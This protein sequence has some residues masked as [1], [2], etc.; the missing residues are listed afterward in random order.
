MTSYGG[1]L[2]G[3]GGL[4]AM[5]GYIGG[6]WGPP[7]MG[8]YFGIYGENPFVPVKNPLN[9]LLKTHLHPL[10]PVCTRKD[11]FSPV[12]THLHHIKTRSQLFSTVKV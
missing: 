4:H 1:K 11:P 6:N 8:G 9:N 10:N 5:G 12:K 7:E 3:F 2:G